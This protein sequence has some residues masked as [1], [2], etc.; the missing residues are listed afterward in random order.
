MTD[1]FEQGFRGFDRERYPVWRDWVTDPDGC[2]RRAAVIERLRAIGV[3]ELP[4][5]DLGW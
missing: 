1:A 3:L 2:P 4:G 5:A